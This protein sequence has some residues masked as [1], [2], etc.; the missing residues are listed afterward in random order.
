M[1]DWI[2]TRLICIYTVKIT[3]CTLFD[4]RQFVFHG[5]NFT[6]SN[7]PFVYKIYYKLV[8]I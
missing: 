7:W 6:L 4:Y 5:S 3:L 2:I 8:L 1:N